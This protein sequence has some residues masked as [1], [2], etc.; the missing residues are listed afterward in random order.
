MKIA[1]GLEMLE[2]TFDLGT[3]KMVIY[4]VV[5]YDANESVLVDTAMP[6]CYATIMEQI[7]QAGIPAAGLRSVILTHQDI[8]HVGSLPHFLAEADG[9]LAVYAHADDKPAIDGKAPF[10]KLNSQMRDGI[11]QALPEKQRNEFEKTFSGENGE[12][13]TH[14]IADGERLPFGG[15]LRVIHTP[16]HTPGHIC[17]FHEPSRTLIAGDAMVVE[18]G[19]LQGPRA[20]ATPDM[21][22]AVQS[23]KK[24]LELPIETVVCYHGGIFKGD[25]KQRLEEIT[26]SVK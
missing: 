14:V 26:A 20:Q 15:G 11:L 8:D 10:L 21:E 13:V 3:R 18:D 4:P 6:G 22:T 25:V 2:L 1:E 16:G 19:Q 12:N 9:P 17:L 7:G 24:L 23:L 5:V